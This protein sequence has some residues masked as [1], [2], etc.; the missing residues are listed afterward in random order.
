VR[1]VP[2]RATLADHVWPSDWALA[3]QRDLILIFGFSLLMI[4]SARVS[5]TLPAA[6]GAAYQALLQPL[7]V[8]LPGTPV[9]VSGQTFAVLLAG[10]TLGSRR[11]AL[12]M[13]AYLGYGLAGLGVFA[14]G[15]SAWT[16]SAIPGVPVILGPTAG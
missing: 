7:G 2:V 6:V 12:S 8:A 14:L 5:F 13:L 1:A 9:P 16:P 15:Q 11:G 4:A 3:R 10:L